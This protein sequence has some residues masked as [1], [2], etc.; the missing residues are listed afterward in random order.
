MQIRSASNTNEVNWDDPLNKGLVA[1]YPFKQKGGNV[2]RDVVGNYDGTLQSS[3][4]SDD[5]VASPETNSLALDFDGTSDRV[6][7]GIDAVSWGQIT[8]SYWFWSEAG[9]QPDS[10]AATVWSQGNQVGFYQ[11]NTRNSH[12]S[13]LRTENGTVNVSV[14]D[15]FNTGGWH[16]V[17]MTWDGQTV[18]TYKDATF[19]SDANLTGSILDT[20]QFTIGADPVRN[21]FKGKIS[22]VRVYDRGLSDSEVHDL[23]QASR[24]GYKD[25]FKRRYFPVSLQTEEPPVETATSG[26][27]RLKSPKRTQPSY[28]AG[29]AKSA[30]ESA[31]PEL[32]DGLKHAW[33]PSLGNSGSAIADLAEG[34]DATNGG[35]WVISPSRGR[36]GAARLASGEDV[37]TDVALV[38]EVWEPWTLSYWI[39]PT[40]TGLHV[41]AAT[42][43]AFQ[44][45]RWSPTQTVF[46]LAGDSTLLNIGFDTFNGPWAHFAVTYDRSVARYYVNGKLAGSDTIGQVTNFYPINDLS[47]HPTTSSGDFDCGLWFDRPLSSNEIKQL[48]TDP[49]APFRQRRYAPVSLVVDGALAYTIDADTGS[50]TL[51]GND[52]Q[53]TKVSAYSISADV[54][55]FALTGNDAQLTKVSAYSI[56]AATGDITVTGN[57]TVLTKVSS[58]TLVAGTGSFTVTGN[59]AALTKV[60]SYSIEAGI[61][62]F[63]LAGN[64]TDLKSDSVI[65]AGTATYTL[66]GNSVGLAY[67]QADPV[68][69]AARGA[70]AVSAG[71]TQLVVARKAQAETGEFSVNG[72][73]TQFRA[74]RKFVASVTDFALDATQINLEVARRVAT[75]T[76]AFLLDGVDARLRYSEEGVTSLIK[77]TSASISVNR[78]SATLQSP[79]SRTS[80]VVP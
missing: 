64:D 37:S 9:S 44:Q 40:S 22:D 23:Y 71:D 26:L 60:S 45:E 16:H 56:A 12:V 55:S 48:Y 13:R 62:S 80:I 20:G 24:T 1:W 21:Y 7:T 69:P 74:S 49:L 67:S 2:L 59:D 32:W 47:F 53:L 79:G 43:G 15:D 75:S 54:G 77:N 11:D 38:P 66:A 8:L 5:W 35:E 70:F 57:N 33:V 52:A 51:T 76:G 42:N 30:S 4:T 61:G 41:K 3:M 18:R 73:D 50:F 46:R 28:K 27:I 39:K 63:A 34:S 29:Y 58:S 72:N 68:L 36:S 31:Y 10:Y 19:V 14:G 78:A 6:T 65:E 25:Q 17:A